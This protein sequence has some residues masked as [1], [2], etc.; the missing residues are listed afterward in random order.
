MDGPGADLGDAMLDRGNLQF[1]HR[2]GLLHDV[3]WSRL[4]GIQY[5]VKQ[6]IRGLIAM[7]GDNSDIL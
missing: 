4:D 6:R 3:Q 5:S 7:T 2:V 1:R